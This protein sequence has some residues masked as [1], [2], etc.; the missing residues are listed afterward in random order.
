MTFQFSL[1]HE[2][3]NKEKP[4]TSIKHNITSYIRVSNKFNL[5]PKKESFLSVTHYSKS[6]FYSSLEEASRSPQK[7]R[8]TL[9]TVLR[10][11]KPD[12][13]SSGSHENP[14]EKYMEL[15]WTD[16]GNEAVEEVECIALEPSGMQFHLPKFP[17]EG[18]TTIGGPAKRGLTARI[19]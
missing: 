9:Y 14:G 11:G 15:R 6:S 13:N 19:W 4:E 17:L 1:L 18:G 5:M 12:Q 3:M 8:S 16:G 7:L 10:K 2:I